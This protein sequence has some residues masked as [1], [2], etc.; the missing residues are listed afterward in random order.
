[1]RPSL[2]TGGGGSGFAF[3]G[4]ALSGEVT[5]LRFVHPTDA[6][7]ARTRRAPLDFHGKNN[8]RRRR[9]RRRLPLGSCSPISG[10]RSIPGQPG[11]AAGRHLMTLPRPHRQLC[12]IVSAGRNSLR[13]QV[14]VSG[15]PHTEVTSNAAG[16]RFL[17]AWRRPTRRCAVCV[18]FIRITY[19][20]SNNTI[21]VI[22]RYVLTYN[23]ALSNQRAFGPMFEEKHCEG[24]CA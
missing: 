2:H 4:F 7:C 11:V 1:M 16:F 17:P 18:N 8:R 15:Q 21:E 20:T 9:H 22:N 24:H 5:G 13:P 10:F 12:V 14:I 19:V 23:T 3:T 6:T